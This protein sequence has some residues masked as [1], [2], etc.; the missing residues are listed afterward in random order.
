MSNP[1]YSWW[2]YVK[3]MIRK[4]P[5]RK[6]HLAS[7][8]EVSLTSSLTGIPHGSKLSDP[9]AN[10]ALKQLPF[11]VQREFDAVDKAIQA[12]K[13]F[14][15]G[16]DRIKLIRLVFWDK[17]HTISG[18]AMQIPCSYDTAQNWHCEFIR[19]TALNYGLLSLEEYEKYKKFT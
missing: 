5:E 10:I 2:G 17:S 18:A 13:R 1:R 14:R 8:H 9:T 11:N 15:D 3:S 19:L 4:Y 12:T 6:E 7:L 16:S